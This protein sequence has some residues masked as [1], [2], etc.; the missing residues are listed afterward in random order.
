MDGPNWTG[1]TND[2]SDCWG[3]L[4]RLPL[5]PYQV[6]YSYSTSTYHG[7]GGTFTSVRRTYLCTDFDLTANHTVKV[8]LGTFQKKKTISRRSQNIGKFAIGSFFASSYATTAPKLPI[9]QRPSFF[10]PLSV[11]PL[12]T[13]YPN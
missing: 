1:S 13:S 12:R 5:L 2:G 10:I 11:H 9:L 6:Q 3:G 7:T 4:A 8:E